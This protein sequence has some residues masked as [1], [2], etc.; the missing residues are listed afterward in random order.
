MVKSSS[1]VQMIAEAHDAI[2]EQGIVNAL[3]DK[4]MDRIATAE[5]T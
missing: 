1:T 2:V 3:K 5:G 4:T